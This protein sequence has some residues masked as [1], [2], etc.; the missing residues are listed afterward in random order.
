MNKSKSLGL[1]AAAAMLALAGCA[2][3]RTSG[4]TATATTANSTVV[5]AIVQQID[6]HF[7]SP[8]V[9]QRA[10]K[11]HPAVVMLALVVRRVRDGL[12]APQADT[13]F[14]H[15]ADVTTS[16]RQ[17]HVRHR[18]GRGRL[19][20]VLIAA[21]HLHRERP[22]LFLLASSVAVLARLVDGL[23]GYRLG[24][25]AHAVMKAVP[26]TAH[27][28]ERVGARLLKD[29][30]AGAWHRSVRISVPSTEK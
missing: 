1:L 20:V 18:H 4:P 12:P 17:R 11:L 9:M 10:V 28:S 21:G 23:A 2:S 30:A 3:Y 7:I 25:P 8:I 27:R 6:N 19:I 24:V 5:M 15:E 14:E 26:V 16:G 22:L 29:D 13:G